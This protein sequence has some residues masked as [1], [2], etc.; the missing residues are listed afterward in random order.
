VTPP[1][2]SILALSEKILLETAR[3]VANVEITATLLSS[4]K[5]SHDF[6]P[7]KK[8]VGQA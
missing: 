7:G 3:S 6:I 4:F 1:D 2:N 5:K 8:V